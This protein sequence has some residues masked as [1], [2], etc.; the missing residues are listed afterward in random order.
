[1]S[2]APAEAIEARVQHFLEEGGVPVDPSFR[3][4]SDGQGEV[5]FQERRLLI[6]PRDK[7]WEEYTELLEAAGLPRITADEV[8]GSDE[9]VVGEIPRD[10]RSLPRVMRG[11]QS[12]HGMTS[13]DVFRM[14]GTTLHSLGEHARAMPDAADLS[15]ERILMLRHDA[16]ILLVPPLSFSGDTDA[17]SIVE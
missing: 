10:A 13:V 9:V 15:L 16:A 6:T 5:I 14:L 1:M 2:I 4:A 8:L 11:E 12:A 7:A 3:V 17:I